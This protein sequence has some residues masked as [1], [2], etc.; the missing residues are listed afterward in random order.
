MRELTRGAARAGGPLV[1][2]LQHRQPGVRPPFWYMRQAGRYLPEYREVRREAGDFLRLC[3]DPELAAEVTLQPVWRFDLDAAIVF[4]DIL[5]IAD[6]LGQE[7][8]YVEREGPRLSPPVRSAGDVER[9][10]R[11]GAVARLRPVFETLARVRGQLAPDKAVIGFAGAPWT[12]AA[13]MVE[14]GNSNQFLA[15]RRWCAAA[16]ETFAALID[17]IV[18]ATVDYLDAQIAAGADMVQLFDSW[19][20]LLAPPAFRRWCVA[21]VAAIVGALKERHPGVPVIAFPRGAGTMLAG[22]ADATGVDAVSLDP[23]VAPE[24][25]IA[26]V[27]GSAALQGN[28]DPALLVAGGEALAQETERILNAFADAPHVFNLGHGIVPETPP[29]HVARLS[30]LIRSWRRV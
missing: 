7:V 18:A 10:R 27:G 16:P 22:Y 30:D 25:A 26:H 17:L 23:T 8:R 20:G 9:L 13:Y 2:L 14:G 12:V 5:L 11:D 1:E 29:D 4:A 3:Y 6:A 24:W 15:A 21:P 28:L 19:S